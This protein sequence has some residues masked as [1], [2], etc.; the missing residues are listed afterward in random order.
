MTF[1]KGTDDKSQFN[2]IASIPC[3]AQQLF[4]EYCRHIMIGSLKNL[5]IIRELARK[6][7][8]IDYGITVTDP[9]MESST[10]DT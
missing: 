5:M 3:K 7:V 1:V 8:V 9:K 10:F 2:F 4:Y 6:D